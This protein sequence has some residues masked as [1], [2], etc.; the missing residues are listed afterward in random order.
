MLLLRHAQG[1]LYVDKHHE[2]HACDITYDD[3]TDTARIHFVKTG[4]ITV[5]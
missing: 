1:K 5:P 4:A 2:N 3:E